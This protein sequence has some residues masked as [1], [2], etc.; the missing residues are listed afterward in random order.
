MNEQETDFK[1]NQSIGH[2]F[3]T[4]MKKLADNES[5]TV[6]MEM[7]IEG[8]TVSFSIQITAIDLKTGSPAYAKALGSQA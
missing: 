2:F 1:G 7:E 4:V 6:E 5:D 3:K 8:A